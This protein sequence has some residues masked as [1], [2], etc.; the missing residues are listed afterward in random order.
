MTFNYRNR[1]LFVLDD[2]NFANSEMCQGFPITS[3]SVIFVGCGPIVRLG[4]M[5]FSAVRFHEGPCTV[6][7]IHLGLISVRTFL[8]CPV[9]LGSVRSC[10]IR[11]C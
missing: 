1:K 4:S 3:R 10:T 2:V 5:L 6:R 8:S 9:P 7:F 11:F